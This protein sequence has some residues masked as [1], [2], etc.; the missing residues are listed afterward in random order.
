M[1]TANLDRVGSWTALLIGLPI[2]LAF[3]FFVLFISLFPLLDF[4]LA[5]IGGGLFWHP[6]VWG[7]LIPLTFAFLLWTAGKRIKSHLDKNYSTIKTSFLFTL[8]VNSWLFGLLLAMFII[9]GLFFNIAPTV[10]F[11]NIS[12]VAIGL[13]ILTFITATGLTS[14][15]IGLL[16]VTITKNKIIARRQFR[17]P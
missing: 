4:G 15:T 8:F 9:G 5:I 1:T 6:I 2:G 10:S 13:T 11:S 17:S 14:V 3:S 12:I 7:G 16:I